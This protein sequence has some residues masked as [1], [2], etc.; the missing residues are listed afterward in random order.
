MPNLDYHGPACGCDKCLGKERK[1][2]TTLQDRLRAAA[3]SPDA[4][5]LPDLMREAADALDERER[6]VRAAYE[7]GF[8]EGE[9]AGISSCHYEKSIGV[10][11]A[12]E[13]SDARTAL[14][15]PREARP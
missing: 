9:N 6:L 8:R 10:V 12:W 1:A 4:F 15:A 14:L 7:E 2:M 5:D 11:K 3:M 13:D